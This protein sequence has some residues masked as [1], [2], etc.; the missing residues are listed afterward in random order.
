MGGGPDDS[1]CFGSP[2]F[3]EVWFAKHTGLSPTLFGLIA[4]FVPL[5]NIKI[6]AGFLAYFGDAV[7]N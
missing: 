1:V 7:V 4:I 3:E 6:H 2:S 5:R